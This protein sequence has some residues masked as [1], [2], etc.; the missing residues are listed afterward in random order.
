MASIHLRSNGQYR[1]SYYFGGKRFFAALKTSVKREAEFTCHRLEANLNDLER[2]RIILPE[3]ADLSRFLL[4]DGKVIAKPIVHVSITL[5]DLFE[6]YEKDFP[7]GVKEE[8]T[9]NM[10]RIHIRRLQKELGSRLNLDKVTRELLQEYIKT[11]SAHKGRGGNRLSHVTIKKELSTLAAVW[12]KYALPL[13]IVSKELSTKGLLYSKRK[14]KPRFQTRSQIERQIERGGLVKNEIAMLWECLFLT[15]PEV[16]ELLSFIKEVAPKVV[17]VMFCL[18]AHSGARRSEMLRVRIDDVD[19]EMERL[20]LREKKR[21]RSK[22]MTFRSVP[23]SPS[24]RA[25]L[26]DWCQQHPGGQFLIADDFGEPLTLSCVAKVFRTT[27]K[28]S[29]WDVMLGW[30]VLRHSFASNCASK[31]IDQRIIDEWMGH[32]TDEMRRRY[33]HLIPSDERLAIQCV[34]GMAGENTALAS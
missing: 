8:N 25:V 14:T 2:G 15:L 30:H 29:K 4:S 31:G 17:Q 6:R 3:G 16:S 33:R 1:I 23:L 10:E 26:L 5:K 7:E 9:R 22:E 32:Q 24:L 27:V 13:G 11:R 21:D 18:A 34:F 28:G 20:V 12:N 19:F